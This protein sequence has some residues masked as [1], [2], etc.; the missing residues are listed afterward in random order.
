MPD[1]N[2]L[3]PVDAWLPLPKAEWNETT[4]RHLASRLGYSVQPDLVE[5]FLKGGPK[6]SIKIALGSIN[7]MPQPEMLVGM[8]EEIEASVMSLREADEIEKREIR[9][10]LRKLNRTGYNDFALQWI[11]FARNPANSCQEKL[12]LFFQNVWVVAFAGVRSTPAL[13]DYQERIRRSIGGTYPEMCK[14]LAVSP[15]MVRYLNLN[16]NRK[17][18]PNENFARELFELFCLGEGN[19]TENDIKEAA[20]A[21]T[22]YVVN[23][24]DE[25]RFI[26]R[27]HDNSRKTIFGQTGNFGLEELIDL[28]FKQP[29]A[30][31]FLPRELVRAYLTEDGLPDQYIAELGTQWKAAGF[32]IP[33]LISTFFSSRLFYDER[34]RDNLIK[35]PFHYY[36]GLLQD[37]DLDVF[38]SPRL[39]TNMIRSMGQAFFNPPNVRGWVGGRHWINSATLIARNRL[40]QSVMNRPPMGQLNADE[41][42]AL[43]KAVEAGEARLQ[44][45]PGWLT[46]LGKMPL[47]EVAKDLAARLY[48]NPD[49]RQLEGILN[50]TVS[51]KMSD[52]RKGVACLIAAL[53]QPAYHLC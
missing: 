29:A 14:H 1:S 4:G 23:Q 30:D 12:T 31:E 18:S 5:A 36:L 19:Y 24:E 48:T 44:V 28:V 11:R 17:G 32:S 47:D 9:Q 2:L 16:Q 21:L 41:K 43:E 6:T 27:R 25:V 49:S 26:D 46:R 38:P 34:F 53:A 13:L 50:E 33:Y 8:M 37:L 39:T 45:D 10:N 7:G 42:A 22:G 15:A 52:R 20:R 40:V 35:S 51:P 3:A